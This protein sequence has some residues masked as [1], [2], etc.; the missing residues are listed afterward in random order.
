MK[1]TLIAMVSALAFVTI[2]VTAA[3]E[4]L[5]AAG[6][7][8]TASAPVIDGDLA[9]DCW[10]SAG[11]IDDFGKLFSGSKPLYLPPSHVKLMYD[12][13]H[14]YVG[15]YFEEPEMAAMNSRTSHCTGA[16]SAKDFAKAPI[17]ST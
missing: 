2:S 13:R 12:A 11:L 14:L 1:T 3:E 17:I 8:A 15:C 7:P 10:T 5:Y 4:V 16:L 9:D 6:C